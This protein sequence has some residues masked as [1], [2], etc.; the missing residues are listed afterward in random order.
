MDNARIGEIISK[1]MEG[2]YEVNISQ[3][4]PGSKTN[5][6]TAKFMSDAHVTAEG[7]TLLEALENCHAKVEAHDWDDKGG[8]STIDGAGAPPPQQ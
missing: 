7:A 3:R 8:I 5:S 1:L 6:F 2:A 4:Q